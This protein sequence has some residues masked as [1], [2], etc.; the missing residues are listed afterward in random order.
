MHQGVAADLYPGPP[1][2]AAHLLHPRREQRATDLSIEKAKKRYAIFR[3]HHSAV[4]RLKQFFPFHLIDAMGSLAETQEAVTT[5]LR[6]AGRGAARGCAVQV[7]G[8]PCG[9]GHLRPSMPCLA[10]Y[11]HVL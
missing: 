4:L 10:A 1:C 8:L 11:A 6:C 3:Q 5:E 7:Q 9:A 2:R